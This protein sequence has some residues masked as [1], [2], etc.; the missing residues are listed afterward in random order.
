MALAQGTQSEPCHQ[1]NKPSQGRLCPDTKAFFSLQHLKQQNSLCWSCPCPGA[2]PGTLHSP[3]CHQSATACSAGGKLLLGSS[4]GSSSASAEGPGVHSVPCHLTGGRITGFNHQLQVGPSK[5]RFG[6]SGFGFAHPQQ[7]QDPGSRAWGAPL[8]F[9]GLKGHPLPWAESPGT[10]HCCSAN[11]DFNQPV[12]N[13]TEAWAG[14]PQQI[15]S[16]KKFLSNSL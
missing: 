14:L 1:Q 16:P 7:G 4:G 10:R 15:S 13:P 3:W 11:P 9:G 2:V 6:A 8:G 5:G 12:P